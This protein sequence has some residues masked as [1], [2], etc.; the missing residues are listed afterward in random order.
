MFIKLFYALSLVGFQQFNLSIFSFILIL[1][2]SSKN[3]LKKLKNRFFIFSFLLIISSFIFL[4]IKGFPLL[5]SIN[6]IKFYFGSLVLGLLIYK[7]SKVQRIYFVSAFLIWCLIEVAYILW[8]GSPPFY[9]ID[10]FDKNSLEGLISRTGIPVGIGKISRITGPTLN[11]S[12]TGVFSGIILNLAIFDK[13]LLLE[14]VSYS[15]AKF[16]TSLLLFTI[17][18]SFL[19]L[20]FSFSGTSILCF[21]TLFFLNSKDYIL[22]ILR[23]LIS[24]R[25]KKTTLYAFMIIILLGLVQISLYY[26]APPLVNKLSFNYFYLVLENKI[27]YILTYF[28]SLNIL[29][30]GGLYDS[31]DLFSF[32]G[33]DK[34]L[35]SFIYTFGALYLLP[36]IFIALKLSEKLKFYTLI[37]ILSSLHY[38]SFFFFTGQILYGHILV[39]SSYTIERKKYQF[40]Q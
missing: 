27:E 13:D 33:G 9:L 11:T 10:F 16:R 24:L 1:I 28:T 12:I 18:S 20:I 19:I 4:F 34:Q 25:I 22:N 26:L 32:W 15:Q 38:G 29:I 5:F 37:L 31:N 36:F 7:S 17:I 23:R 21:L 35:I 3:Y 30:L 40:N 8:T 6:L 2:V 39:S 14:G